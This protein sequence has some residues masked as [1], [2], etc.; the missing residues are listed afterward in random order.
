MEAEMDL[1]GKT[2]LV[3][4]GGRGIGKSICIGLAERGADIIVADIDEAAAKD[5][6]KEVS[7]FGVKTA[8]FAFDVS[9]TAAAEKVLAD[10][11]EDFGK[12]DILVNNAGVTRD[13]LL[14]RMKEEDWDFVLNINLKGVFNCSKAAAR[15]MMKARSG[16]IINISSVVGQI[17]NAGQ[18][19]YSASKAGVIGL[20]KTMAKE[21]AA[22]GITVNAIAP[23]YIDTQMTKNLPEQA[24]QA[25][26]SI[27]PLKRLGQPEDIAN[28]VVFLAS[29]LADYITGQVL[30]VDGGMVM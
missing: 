16:R 9:N 28:A 11:V 27:V 15:Y 8:A 5:T 24:K 13:T 6:A 23:G 19:N 25:L 26:L 22:R 17:G 10:I 18:A 12:I 20:T 2:A 29:P 3:T 14:M 1:R 4:G 21:L 30:R 7:G